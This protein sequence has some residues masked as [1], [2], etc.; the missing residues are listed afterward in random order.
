MRCAVQ[1]ETLNPV[2]LIPPRYYFDFES[3]TRAQL[4][5]SKPP[6]QMLSW[7]TWLLLFWFCRARRAQRCSA[8]AARAQADGAAVPRCLPCAARG[9]DSDWDGADSVAT[10]DSFV[11]VPLSPDAT[12]LRDTTNTGHAQ[13]ATKH[14]AAAAD[15]TFTWLDDE[16]RR[17]NNPGETSTGPDALAGTTA[18]GAARELDDVGHLHRRVLPPVCGAAQQGRPA[19]RRRHA[20]HRPE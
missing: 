4:G 9:A 11:Q 18:G 7:H 20:P 12:L 14:R 15:P 2:V 13:P 1:P 10:E 19:Q 5:S 17:R 8:L 3:G 6:L 16:A